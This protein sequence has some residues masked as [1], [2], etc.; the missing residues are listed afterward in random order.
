M[1]IDMAWVNIEVMA[2]VDNILNM[3]D[4]LGGYDGHGLV[5]YG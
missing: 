2:W 1:D 4:D 3:V 5:G